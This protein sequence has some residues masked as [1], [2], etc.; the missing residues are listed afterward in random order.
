MSTGV[1]DQQLLTLPEFPNLIDNPESPNQKWR[2]LIGS[3]LNSCKSPAMPGGGRMKRV[4]FSIWNGSLILVLGCAGLWAQATAEI[5]GSV[6]DQSGAVLPGVEVTATQIDTGIRRSSITNETGSYAL[7][8]LPLGPYRFEA[9]LPGFRAF[10]QTG[11]VLQVNSNPVINPVLQLGQL[12]ETVEVQANAAQVETRSTAVGQVI[13]NERILELPLNGR[14]VTDLITLSG[15]AVQTGTGSNQS[16]NGGALISVAG[17]LPFGVSYA[18]D[19]A[20]HTDPYE[21][22]NHPMPFPDALQEFKVEAGGMAANSGM[23]SGGNVNAVTKSGTN[24]FHGD[25]FEFVR[26][27]KFNARNFFAIRRDSLKRN[28]FGGIL[29]GPIVKNKLFFFGAYQGTKTRSDPGDTIKYVPTAAMLTGDWTTFTSPACNAGR[30]ITLKEPFVNN[31]IDPAQ[32]SKVS[33]NIVAKLPKP[34]DACGKITYGLIEK[35]NELQAVGKVDYQWSAKHSIF[36]R[37]LATTYAL[38]PPKTFSDNIL[39]STNAGFDNLAQAYALGSTYLIGPTTVNAFRLT[40]NRTA[41]KRYHAPIFSAPDVGINSYSFLKDF[42]VLSVTGGF[43]IG[44]GTQSL[45]TFRTTSYQAS[46]DISLVMGTHQTAFGLNLAHWRVNQFSHVRDNGQYSFNSTATGLGMADFFTGRLT[47]LQHGSQVAWASGQDYAAVYASDVWKATRKITLTYGARWEPFLPLDIR[48]GTPYS[49]SFDR[50]RQGIKSQVYPNAPAGLYFKGDPGFPTTGSPMNNRWKV[51]NPRVGLAWDVDGNGS[52]SV[53]AS[54]GIATDF[55]LGRQFGSGQSAPPNGFLTTVDSP[56]GGFEDPWL[57]YPGGTPV[58]YNPSAARF[59][60]GAQ[61][62]PVARYDMKPPYVQS[63]T[64]SIQRQISSD[65][66]ASGS[67][68]GSTSVHLWTLRNLNNAIYFPGSPVNGVCTAGGSTLRTNATTCSATGNTD[69]RRKLA[70]EN[71]AEG[72]Y[73]G[74]INSN[75]DGGTG[76]YHGMLLSIQRRAGNGTNIGANYTW[77]HCINNGASFSHNS[78]GSYL[79][80]DNRAFD[81]GNCDSDRRHALNLTAVASAPKFSNP[82][83]QRVA[84][85]WRL[86]GIY[87]FSTGSFLTLTPGTDRALNGEPDSQ[88][89]NQVLVNPYADRKSLGYLNTNAFA[90]PAPG[91]I[92]NMSPRNIEGPPIW[93]FDLALSRTFQFRETQKLEFRGEAFNVTNSLIR[94]APTLAQNSNTFGQINTSR[95]ARIMQFVLKYIF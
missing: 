90:L 57:G 21:G 19:G 85:G 63:W 1:A 54:F 91:T 26:N 32:Y 44:G 60:P 83:L 15:A 45:A 5:S 82:T 42:M 7:P 79:D 61:F 40:V 33:M 22:A 11:I 38:L 36:G 30:L 13:E 27:Y 23:R 20:M 28:Q 86:S 39:T 88:R 58:P 53:R 52:T 2:Q 70:V 46:D 75:E 92:G 4:V 62:L 78:S 72:L 76:S 93:Q 35:P 29:G 56:A 25:L 9:V 66:L 77:S 24:E 65:W 71:P 48:L 50:F 49:F 95:P 74:L 51:F 3:Q 84:A 16:M 43:N 89:P 37:Y 41:I 94:L 59:T 68:L 87:R 64:L 18:L 67:Y 6:R 80:P 81:R 55:T 8:N 14:Q 12:A 73:Y 17:G 10:V 34:D 47:S 69:Q 31:R